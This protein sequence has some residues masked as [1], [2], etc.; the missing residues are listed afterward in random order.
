[1]TARE[2]V[3]PVVWRRAALSP[4]SSKRAQLANGWAPGVPD[5]RATDADAGRRPREAG[6]PISRWTPKLGRHVLSTRFGV[7]YS[8]ERVRQL[9]HALGWRVR[10]VRHRH[11]KATRHE[12]TTCLL[13]QQCVGA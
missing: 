4:R 3:A 13:R 11:L 1:M 5:G 8:R 7:A 6:Y 2:A 10:R 9:L 12:H